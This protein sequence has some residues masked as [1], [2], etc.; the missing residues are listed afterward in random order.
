[1]INGAGRGASPRIVSV[2]HFV[3]IDE[4]LQILYSVLRH[5]GKRKNIPKFNYLVIDYGLIL[6]TIYIHIHQS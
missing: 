1:V 4:Q 5:S 2:A 6:Y 3:Y